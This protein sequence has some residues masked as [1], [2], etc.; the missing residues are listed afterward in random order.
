MKTC[1]LCQLSLPLT[2]FYK[3]KTGGFGVKSRCIK[4]YYSLQKVWHQK[5]RETI[6]LNAKI[7]HSINPERR[8]L[9]F[10][11]WRKKNLG[12]DAMRQRERVAMQ[13]QA[14]PKWADRDKIKEIYTNCPAGFHVDH[15]IPLCGKIVSGLHVEFNLQYLTALE[16]I[17]K[18][19]FY[20]NHVV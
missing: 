16:N 1:S 10:T 19:N 18:K 11:T 5:N 17:R 9:S 4:C 13:R 14:M 6:N 7:R 20:E 2:A 15:V 3:E 12:H 8:R